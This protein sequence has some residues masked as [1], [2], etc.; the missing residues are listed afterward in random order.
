M[1]DVIGLLLYLTFYL[2]EPGSL[3]RPAAVVSSNR[4]VLPIEQI[5]DRSCKK[6]S[7]PP[8]AQMLGPVVND[9]AALAER[10]QVTA[11]V[12]P[13]I[14]V[15]MGCRQIDQ[16]GFQRRTGEGRGLAAL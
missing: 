4:I 14:A 10:A 3:E 8:P 12:M 13:G 11:I 2:G 15:Q 9:M 6:E 7:H 16:C 5:A 1:V